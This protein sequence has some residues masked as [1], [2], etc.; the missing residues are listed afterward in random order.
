LKRI[1][2]TAAA[3]LV[4]AACSSAPQPSRPAPATADTA[5]TSRQPA[6][7]MVRVSESFRPLRGDSAIRAFAPEI[8]PVDSAGEC[9]TGRTPGSGVT[10]VSA[11]FPTRKAPQTT[12]TLTFDSVGHLARY[13]EIRGVPHLPSPVGMT[14]AQRDSAVR[15]ATNATRSTSLSFDYAIDQA[16]VM[17]RGGAKPTEAIIGTIRSIERLDKLGP[18]VA[19]IERARKLCGV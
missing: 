2:L 8:A 3:A 5:R 13:S 7:V 10:M 16:I 9:Y 11:A 1:G 19:R 17:N 18:P 6:D 4:V 12:I 14:N 15:A